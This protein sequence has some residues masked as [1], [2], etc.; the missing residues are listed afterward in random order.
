VNAAARA[1]VDRTSLSWQRTA[2]HS[3]LVALFAAI[4]AVRLGEPAVASAAG[5]LILTAVVVAATTPRVHRSTA[6]RRDP[7][8]LMVRTAGVVVLS[9]V[10]AV[11]LLVAVQVDA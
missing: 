3:T 8:S 11:V 5:V 4:T 9:A 6:E 2:A 7:W 10:V 1:P